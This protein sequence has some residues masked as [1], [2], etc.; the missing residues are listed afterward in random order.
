M[1]KASAAAYNRDIARQTPT[2]C[3]PTIYDA[4][5]A[6]FPG[7]RHSSSTIRRGEDF[8]TRCLIDGG[9]GMISLNLISM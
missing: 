8:I 2:P 3:P 5:I 7:Q 6:G 1:E 4:E 9:A